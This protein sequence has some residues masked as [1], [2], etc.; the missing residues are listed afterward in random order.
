[1]ENE[2]ADTAKNILQLVINGHRT[3]IVHACVNGFDQFDLTTSSNM[4]FIF[5]LH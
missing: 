4:L 2:C 1:M 3:Y 5:T